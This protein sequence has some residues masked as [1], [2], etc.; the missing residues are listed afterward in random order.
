M[1]KTIVISL[2]GSLIIPEKINFHFLHEFKS[3]LK[4]HFAKYKFVI[5]CGGGTIARKYISALRKEGK[6]KREL[7]HAGIR[8]T[9]MN[10]Q[11][12]MQMFSRS[13]ANDTLPTTMK[14]IKSNLQKNNVVVCGALRFEPNSTSDGTAAKLAHYLKTDFINMTNVAGLYNKDPTKHKN[15]K[16]IPK[17]SWK[18]F[19]SMISKIKFKAGQNFVLD[20]NAAITIKKHKIKTYLIGSNKDL[21]KILKRKKVKGTLIEG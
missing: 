6:S 9:R 7:A 15:A 1:K 20:Q 10:A 11:F 19:N 5:V 12:I 8:A 2:G 3:I 4:R 17:I 21:D 13:E 14:Q 16:F 18:D